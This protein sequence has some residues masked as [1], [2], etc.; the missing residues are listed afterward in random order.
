LPAPSEAADREHGARR[1]GLLHGRRKG[2]KLSSHQAALFESLLPRLE[3]DLRRDSDPETW[4]DS[5]VGDVWLEI[6][7][8]AGEHLLWQARHH[9]DVGII[10]AEPYE[11]GI[12]KLLSKLFS[13]SSSTQETEGE[14][15]TGSP[16]YD[17]QRGSH[18]NI[19]LYQGDARDVIEALP[20]CSLGRVF[21]LFPD[22]WPKKRH[23]K[24]RFIQ[25][26][27][28]DEFARVL[29][30]GADLRFASDDPG[31][32]EWALEHFLAHHAFEWL[33]RRAR[34]WRTRPSDWPATR[35][36]EK[37]LHGAPVFLGFRRRPLQIPLGQR[38]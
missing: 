17:R 36:E 37:A 5:C 3:L 11:A 16:D 9:P 28:L 6:G 2:P 4:F 29:K 20:D 35:Y 22:P 1:R 15:D 14:V 33:A 26:R 12:A 10:G 18:F 30:P 21:I 25:T 31:Y 23:H 19:R 8:G 38:T 7:F 24:R 27:I 13:L 32:V 34:D